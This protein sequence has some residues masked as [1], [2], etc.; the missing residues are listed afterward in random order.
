MLLKRVVVTG[1]GT[2]NPLG[3][4]TTDFFS[5]LDKGISG[6]C[7]ITLFDTTL[8]KTHFACQVQNFIFTNY[9]YDRKDENKNDRFCQFALVSADEAIKDC[10]VDFSKEN[11][12][13]VGVVYGSGVGG[14]E[15]LT[16]EVSE[17]GATGNPRFSP[18]LIPKILTDTAAGQISIRN[19]F[20]GPNFGVTSA[21]ASSTNAI[22]VGRQMI[23][24]SN[25]DMMLVGGSEAPICPAGLGG[26]NSMHAISTNNDEY[27][28]ASRP[29]D[30]KR[31]G[32]VI[33]EGAASII[34]EEYEHAVARGAH[35]YAEVAG[36]GYSADAYHMTSPLADG[37]GAVQALENALLDAGLQPSDVDYINAHGTSTVQGDVAELY[38]IKKV[39]GD[40]SYFPNI[41]STKSM[42]GHLLGAAGAVETLACIHALNSGIIPPTINFREEDENIDYKMK[43]TF[44]EPVERKV[45]VAV[46]NSF[47]FSGH[48]TCLILKSL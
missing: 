34:L 47:G 33:A 8:F 13:R 15:T 29:F 4:N 5:A 45:K 6:A 28:T 7:F 14:L 38:A 12:R 46:N 40:K 10:G 44:N 27:K 2:V 39:F 19:G 17:Y 24:L 30:K 23:Q 37:T 22:C 32:F 36:S 21:C 41:S 16:R 3:N 42:T 25:A 9:G 35:I 48:N 1:I 26:F 11:L 43:I 18:F 20:K 31:D